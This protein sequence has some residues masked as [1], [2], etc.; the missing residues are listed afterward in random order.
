MK[1]EDLF[2]YYVISNAYSRK[3]SSLE[4]SFFLSGCGLWIGPGDAQPGS[5]VD[6]KGTYQKLLISS[7]I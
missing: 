1:L 3:D 2:L 7:Y 5:I 4:S 6:L